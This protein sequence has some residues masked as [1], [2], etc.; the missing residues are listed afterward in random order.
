MLEYPPK[1]FRRRSPRSKRGDNR[2]IGR[3]SLLSLSRGGRY[4]TSAAPLP[5]PASMPAGTLSSP[6]EER[7]LDDPPTDSMHGSPKQAR[8]KNHEEN[9]YAASGPASAPQERDRADAIQT[10]LY[11]W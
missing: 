10:G 7:K 4:A 9:Q 3:C 11:R 8:D 6:S 1:S 5:P 2:W